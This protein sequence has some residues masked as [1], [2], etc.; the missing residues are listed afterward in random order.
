MLDVIKDYY[1]DSKAS[2]QTEYLRKT[3]Q[4][5]L[6]WQQW[7]QKRMSHDSVFNGEIAMGAARLSSAVCV[8][9]RACFPLP[10]VVHRRRERFRILV[11][12][13]RLKTDT[14]ISG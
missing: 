13:L 2:D 5:F 9:A 11:S 12:D 14:C 7:S 1:T 10:E 6:E 4:A 8:C 3:N